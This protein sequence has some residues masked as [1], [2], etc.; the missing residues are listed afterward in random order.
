MLP[1]WHVLLGAIFSLIIWFFSPGINPFYIGLIF[2]SSF[3]IDFDHYLWTIKYKKSLSLKC[4]LD[5]YD[6]EFPKIY[7]RDKKKGL[8]KKYFLH[9]FHTVEFLILIAIL[10]FFWVGFFYIS[11]GM[12][13][14][15][16]TDVI[17]MFVNDDLHIKEFFFLSWFF[18]KIR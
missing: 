3:L 8:R 13:F 6:K 2:L 14:H 9:I 7:A 5:F 10:S 15:F 18:R 12:I 11:I 16:L 17:F 1:R 4:S